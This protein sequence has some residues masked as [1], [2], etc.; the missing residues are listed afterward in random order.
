MLTVWKALSKLWGGHGQAPLAPGR[1]HQSKVPVMMQPCL[2]LLAALLFQMSNHGLI[3]WPS[4]GP[5]MSLWRCLMPG[6]GVGVSI[7]VH[8]DLM[9]PLWCPNYDSI[10]LKE[11]FQI[12]GSLFCSKIPKKTPPQY[13]SESI[14]KFMWKSEHFKFPFWLRIQI[15]SWIVYFPTRKEKCSFS[16]F[17]L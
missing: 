12:G 10:Q 5:F 4:F 1:P 13:I 8:K 11:T 2:R 3:F 17:Y 6:L 14:S 9:W 15:R 16:Q 7:P